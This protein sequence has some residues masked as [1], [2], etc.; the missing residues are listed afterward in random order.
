MNNILDKEST[1]V[2]VA[3]RM[4][5]SRLPLKAMLDVYGKPLLLRLIE[6]IAET[7]PLDKIVICTSIHSQ[8]NDIEHFAIQHK[9]NYFRGDEMDVMGRFIN[10]AKKFNAKTIVR[11]TGDNP[12]TDP[13]VLDN[14]IEFH[15][16]KQAEYTFT[17]DLPIGTRAEVIDVSALN[18]IYNQLSDPMHSEYMTLMLKRPDKLKVSEFYTN[19]TII[20]RPELSLTVDTLEDINLVRDIYSSFNENIPN[21]EKIITWLDENPSKK[22]IINNSISLSKEI[23]YSYTDDM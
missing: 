13:V 15:L 11:V 20:K 19:N 16:S 9:F 10:A 7:V 5:S 1:Y 3:V 14:M 21:L 6:R 17:N 2:F 18:R 8:D 12:L 23:N 22:I 4:K